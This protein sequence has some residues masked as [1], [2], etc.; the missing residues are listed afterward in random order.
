MIFKILPA[1]EPILLTLAALAKT[2]VPTAVFPSELSPN[3]AVF[4]NWTSK[5]KLSVEIKSK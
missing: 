4:K 3:N 1:R 5:S 2:T